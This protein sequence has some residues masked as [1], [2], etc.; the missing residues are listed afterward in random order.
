MAFKAV[1]PENAH[2]GAVAIGNGGTEHNKQS[3]DRQFGIW[4]AVA[5]GVMCG[6]AWPLFGGTIVSAS[7]RSSKRALTMPF[8]V[9]S[10]YNGG[11]PGVLYE[12]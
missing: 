7:L 1:K 4:S 6:C 9:I 12:L 10:L 5:L 3:M 11:P 8:Q 2:E